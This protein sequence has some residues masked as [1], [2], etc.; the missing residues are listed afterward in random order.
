MIDW[1]SS[2]YTNTEHN[3]FYIPSI[4]E[5]VF[6]NKNDDINEHLCYEC[7]DKTKTLKNVN[8]IVQQEPQTDE[9][10]S[11]KFSNNHVN[12]RSNQYI[13]IHSN[14]PVY[15]PFQQPKSNFISGFSLTGDNILFLFITFLLIMVYIELR[16]SNI[17]KNLKINNNNGNRE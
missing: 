13:P 14:Q 11:E 8:D 12:Q 17:Y 4:D 1:S 15:I 16:I 6:L 3:L 5:G 10:I 7:T 9:F 2:D